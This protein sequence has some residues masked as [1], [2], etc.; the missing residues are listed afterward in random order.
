MPPRALLRLG[1]RSLLVHKLRSTLSILGVFFGVAAVVAVSS[2]GEG[3]RR[4]AL[5]QIGALGVDTVVVRVKPAAEGSREPPV[6][7]R[8]RDA[9]SLA[10]VVPGVVGTAALREATLVAEAGERH[11]ELLTVGTTPGY[12]VASRLELAAGRFLTDLDVSDRKR[13]AVLGAAVANRLYPLADPL[14]RDLRLGGDWYRVVGVLEG[15]ARG[16]RGAGPIR[17][18]D[19][20]EVVF[21]PL[22]ALDRGPAAGLDDVSEIVVR[23]ASA[24]AV[25]AGADVARAVLE[26]KAG[27]G[28][29]EVVVPREILRQ[30][31]ETQ[32][33]F[34][35][36]T[37]VIAAISLLVGGIGI[38]NIML[39]SVAERTREIGVRRAVGATRRAVAAQFLVES[40][41]L[42]VAG[43]LLGAVLGV[44]GSFAI[45][46]LAGWPTALS[47]GLLLAALL[48]ALAVG[49]GFGLY[50]AWSAARLE[51]M[52]ALRTE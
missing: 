51:P 6:P 36:V 14:G 37:G 17:T 32:R 33:I 29:F 9:D 10:A 45:Q 15:R 16:R 8:E 26:R 40:S 20:N 49:I 46:H 4:E 31:E 7:L 43:G 5:A 21:V 30:R 28:A 23:L 35:V 42:T 11:A 25:L 2:V 19:V 27:R 47:P 34:N 22:P 48:M 3:A 18:R 12:R 1:V 24:D 50:P 52:E 44:L 41:I 13:V 38:M 39:A